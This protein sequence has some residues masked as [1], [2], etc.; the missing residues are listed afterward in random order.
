MIFSQIIQQEIQASQNTD[1]DPGLRR[2]RFGSPFFEKE[3]TVRSGY[4]TL[5]GQTAI[6]VPFIQ[7]FL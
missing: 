2:I 6:I 4:T 7:Y 5:Y 1:P 3:D